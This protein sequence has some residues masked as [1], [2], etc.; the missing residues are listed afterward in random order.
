MLVARDLDRVLMDAVDAGT[1]P[2]VVALA[3][4]AGEVVYTG[5]FGARG[6]DNDQPMRLDTVV[7][8]ASMTKAVTS[9]AAMQLVEQ[10]RIALDEPVGTHVPELATV[11][12]LEGFDAAGVPRLR[13]PRRAITLRHLLTHTAGFAYHFWNASMLRYHDCTGIPTI[14]SLKK[15]CLGVPLVC[16]PGD[17]WEYGLSTDWVGQ[18]V[19]RLSGQSLDDYFREHILDPLGMSDTGFFIGS[20]QRSRL[21]VKHARQPDGSL[22]PLPPGETQEPEFLEGGGGLYSTGP[23]YLRFLRMLL[24]NGQLE[25][26][27]ILR[28]ETTAEM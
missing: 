28:A 4:D 11:Q 7:E 13:P 24:G 6:I 22:H 17:C 25:G 14:A 1:V 16:D 18:T 12:V 27:R 10:G 2:G 19:E 15:T 23:D 20:E 26:V 9:V 8:I 21:A 3:A 5:A